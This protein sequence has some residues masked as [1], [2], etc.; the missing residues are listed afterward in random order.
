VGASLTKR[1][2]PRRTGQEGRTIH[3]TAR[4]SA[5]APASS[6]L[7]RSL[8][9]GRSAPSDRHRKSSPMVVRGRKAS[10]G[11][12]PIQADCWALRPRGWTS[13]AASWQ[14]QP[15]QS[16]HA[17]QGGYAECAGIQPCSRSGGLVRLD[18]SDGRCRAQPDWRGWPKPLREATGS[19]FSPGLSRPHRRQKRTTKPSVGLDVGT[20]RFS[21]ISSI[22]STHRSGVMLR[23]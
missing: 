2:G 18:V 15:H 12:H 5:P 10:R 9:N 4:R 3:R 14:R 21:L 17:S 8:R 23:R 11:R 19:L 6:A 22:T 13:N 7:V 20:T 16:S 1:A